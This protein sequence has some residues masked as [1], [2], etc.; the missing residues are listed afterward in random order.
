ML[1]YNCGY[2]GA[3]LIRC[4]PVGVVLKFKKSWC[5]PSTIIPGLYVHAPW[6]ECCSVVLQSR[7]TEQLLNLLRECGVHTTSSVHGLHHLKQ[8]AVPLLTLH[9]QARQLGLLLDKTPVSQTQLL[10]TQDKSCQYC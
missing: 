9:Y 3:G 4:E 7:V 1:I 5:K 6:C 2:G 8:Q 10:L